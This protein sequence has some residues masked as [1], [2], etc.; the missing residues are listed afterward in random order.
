MVC[1]WTWSVALQAA[2]L[3][4]TAQHW[5]ETARRFDIARPSSIEWL[6]SET[7]LGGGSPFSCADS[8]LLPFCMS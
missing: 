5:S 4:R 2:A 6:Y 7:S 8:V 3:R 1:T